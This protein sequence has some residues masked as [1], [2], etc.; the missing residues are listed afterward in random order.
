VAAEALAEGLLQGFFD[1]CRFMIALR[2]LYGPLLL[3]SGTAAM[4]NL[5][6]VAESGAAL[7]LRRAIAMIP[8]D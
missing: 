7:A 1:A 3:F 8:L 6:A 2:C 4:L 5:C